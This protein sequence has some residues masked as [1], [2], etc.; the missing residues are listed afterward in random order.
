MMAT[1]TVSYDNLP[2][3]KEVEV[4]GLGLLVN[5][6]DNEVDDARWERFKNS[7]GY[8]SDSLTLGSDTSD[9]HTPVVEEETQQQEEDNEQEE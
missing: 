4:V 1:V 2:K 6:Q 3:G 7:T 5:G 8:D 9:T